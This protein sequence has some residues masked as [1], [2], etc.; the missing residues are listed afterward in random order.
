[1]TVGEL[2]GARLKGMG[3]QGTCGQKWSRALGHVGLPA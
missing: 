1:M 3:P 2:I